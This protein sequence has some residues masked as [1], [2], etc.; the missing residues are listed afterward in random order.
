MNAPIPRLRRPEAVDAVVLL[1]PTGSGK[2]PLGDAVALRGLFG[3]RAHHLDF[4]K[5]LRAAASAGRRG[6]DYTAE[7]TRFIEDVLERGLLLENEHFGLAG[8]IIGLFL[9]RQAFGQSD[10][11]VLNGI[12]RHAGQAADLERFASV[13]ALVVLD[14]PFEDVFCR[15]RSNV[16]GDRAGRDDDQEGLV[17]QKIR[18]FRE[19]T[20]PLIAYYA[21][22]GC[23]IYRIAISRE[24][25]AARAY[26][27]LSALS[28]V[29][30]PVALVAEPPQ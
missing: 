6:R 14:C 21:E 28:A 18:T 2:S 10:L 1:G 16:G 19:R 4:G 25:T 22:R 11:L 30:P 29:D 8:K 3:R 7:E 17:E 20:A 26:R 24:T 9:A 23:G 15:L 27:E 5:E 13:R 12:P